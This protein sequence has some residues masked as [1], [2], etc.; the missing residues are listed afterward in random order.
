MSDQQVNVAAQR[1]GQLDGVLVGLRQKILSI[2][3][4]D[5]V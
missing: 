2:L 1:L 4:T 3:L 5:T